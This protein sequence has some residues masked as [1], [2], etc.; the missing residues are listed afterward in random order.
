MIPEEE[1]PVQLCDICEK[2]EAVTGANGYSVCSEYCE[3]EARGR[4]PRN[5]EGSSMKPKT[6]VNPS[7]GEWK[8]TAMR[9]ADEAWVRNGESVK[10]GTEKDSFIYTYYLGALTGGA[11][12]ARVLESKEDSPR[13]KALLDACKEVCDMCGG[14]ALRYEQSVT[15]PNSAGNYTH[16]YKDQGDP[17]LCKASSVWSLIRIE[18]SPTK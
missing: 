18:G 11:E 9:L 7:W 16:I 10:K 3:G 1:E 13:R 5:N 14:R 6:W 8:D 17:D 12:M 15:G 2:H 4:P